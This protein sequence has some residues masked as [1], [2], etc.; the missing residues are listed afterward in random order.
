MRG[1]PVFV[2]YGYSNCYNTIINTAGCRESEEHM[3]TIK[4]VTIIG[5]GGL[6]TM[7]GYQIQ[8]KIGRENV[9]FLM[10]EV[11]YQKNKDAVYKVNGE[12]YDFRIITPAEAKP[13]DLII[14]ATKATGLAEALD[15]MAPAVGP[16][17]II[18][19]AI[20]GVMSEEILAERFGAEKVIHAVAQ[21]M[22]ATFFG[23]E[24]NYKKPGVF[25]LGIIDPAMQ[26]KLEALDAFFNSIDFVHTIENDIR[27]R[28]WSKFMLNVGVN[29]ACM[30]FETG[31]GGISEEGS[32]PRLV[33]VSAMREAKLVSNAEGITLTEDDLVGYVDLMA[34]LS[35]ESMPSM[36]QDRVNKKR[37]EV[38]LFAGT[39]IR[40]AKK[41]GFIVPTNEYLY[42]RVMEIEAEY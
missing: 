10:D 17:T 35:P 39:V 34:S 19:S 7:F 14:V 8:N 40:L 36:A 42:K 27:H 25:C 16:D 31:Y 15:T 12:P 1:F 29:Q 20:N 9:S 33:M 30:V 4:N 23:H 38:E 3:S 2:V 18:I 22:D 6:G 26:G 13:A 32:L 5:M 41:H 37:S 28:I 21:G 24:L 11:R